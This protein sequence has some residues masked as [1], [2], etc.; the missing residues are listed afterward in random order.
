MKDTFLIAERCK[1]ESRQVHLEAITFI[2]FVVAYFGRKF[3]EIVVACLQAK[4]T[5]SECL[6][7][8]KGTCQADGGEHHDCNFESSHC[9]FSQRFGMDELIVVDD[10][11]D[12]DDDEP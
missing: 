8:S 1:D 5:T 12:G 2:V 9:L 6:D 11:D 4:R 3:G 10:D 7:R